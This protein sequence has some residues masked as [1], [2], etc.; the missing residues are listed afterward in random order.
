MLGLGLYYLSNLVCFS[1]VLYKN[2]VAEGSSVKLFL[3]TVS[4]AFKYQFNGTVKKE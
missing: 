1:S 3:L 4:L 2:F